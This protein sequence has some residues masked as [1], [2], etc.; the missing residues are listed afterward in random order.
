MHYK[1]LLSILTLAGIMPS[2]T[3]ANCQAGDRQFCCAV[4]EVPNKQILPNLYLF[5]YGLGCSKLYINQGAIL[6]CP[7]TYTMSPE[8][9]SRTE[10]CDSGSSQPHGICCDAPDTVVSHAPPCFYLTLASFR[11]LTA[12]ATE[13]TLLDTVLCFSD[14]AAS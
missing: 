5:V 6:V 11:K 12:D 7:K 1:A 3:S 2:M 9:I 8:E 10:N 4:E 14:H 13:Q